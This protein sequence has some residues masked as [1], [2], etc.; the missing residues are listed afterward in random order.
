M[1]F[2]NDIYNEQV[3]SDYWQHFVHGCLYILSNK[4]IATRSPNIDEISQDF[5]NLLI[6]KYKHIIIHSK[7]YLFRLHNKVHCVSNK[8]T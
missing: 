6:P 4:E 8:F 5:M 1:G 3:A 7:I 2:P